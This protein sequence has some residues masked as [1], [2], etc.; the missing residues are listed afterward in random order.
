MLEQKNLILG[1]HQ[2]FRPGFG[3]SG[4]PEGPR[5]R[6]QLRRLALGVVAFPSTEPRVK[7]SPCGS[8][9]RVTW[10][11]CGWFEGAGGSPMTS[12]SSTRQRGHFPASQCLASYSLPSSLS[13]SLHN[14]DKK[15]NHLL[16]SVDIQSI[17]P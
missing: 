9:S 6:D 7:S 10:L 15:Q 11:T 8:G 17:K 1:T 5:N 12:L 3:V 13:L 14:V 2:A 4:T 16:L